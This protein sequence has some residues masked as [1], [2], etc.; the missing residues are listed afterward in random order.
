M[1]RVEG[2]VP[3]QVLH[4]ASAQVS[5]ALVTTYAIE[6]VCG[7]DVHTSGATICFRRRHGN[8]LLRWEVLI[9]HNVRP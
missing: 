8:N 5:G 3:F 4:C 1:R 6:R 2:C 9:L 7:R